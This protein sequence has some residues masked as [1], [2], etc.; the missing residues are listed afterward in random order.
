MNKV[1]Q[2]EYGPL[3]P[4][5]RP[6]VVMLILLIPIVAAFTLSWL[7]FNYIYVADEVVNRQHGSTAV[8]NETIKTAIT[9]NELALQ[10]RSRLADFDNEAK[11]IFGLGHQW[12]KDGENLT[13]TYV[14]DFVHSQDDNRWLFEYRAISDWRVAAAEKLSGLEDDLDR[15][16]STLDANT[17]RDASFE[18]ERSVQTIELSIKEVDDQILRL[19]RF[20]E[21]YASYSKGQ[22]DVD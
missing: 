20:G 4:Y 17:T 21:K 11:Q 7:V 3:K 8:T 9:G 18:A 22:T 13:P 19:R 12:S 14:Y 16:V 1:F 15:H 2:S 6:L 5:Q 10:L